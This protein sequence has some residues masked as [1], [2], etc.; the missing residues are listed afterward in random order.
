MPCSGAV[1]VEFGA[2]GAASGGAD[3]SASVGGGAIGMPCRIAT[4]PP[5]GCLPHALGVCAPPFFGAASGGVVAPERPVDGLHTPPGQQEALQ[6]H[7]SIKILEDC[8]WRI[9]LEHGPLGEV[10]AVAAFAPGPDGLTNL[11]T[12]TPATPNT[13]NMLAGLAAG[14]EPCILD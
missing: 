11:D 13:P 8:K 14:G 6:V 12:S 5:G 10:V 7:Q 4:T 9:I 3:E 2:S 1:G